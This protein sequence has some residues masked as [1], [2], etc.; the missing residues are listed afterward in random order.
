MQL[1]YAGVVLCRLF[2]ADGT[3]AG[4]ILLS[5]DKDS[6]D[7]TDMVQEQV[8]AQE[9]ASPEIFQRP[10]QQQQQQPSQYRFKEVLLKLGGSKPGRVHTVSVRPAPSTPATLCWRHYYN[11]FLTACTFQI[12]VCPSSLKGQPHSFCMER[13]HAW[14]AAIATC[15]PSS[16]IGSSSSTSSSK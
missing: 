4:V 12:Y 16:T 2:S 1:Y 7:I 3:D 10:Q 8:A 11:L 15:S 13:A 6:Y 14:D 9:Y 5:V